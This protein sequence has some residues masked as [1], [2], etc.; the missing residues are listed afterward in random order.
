MNMVVFS[1]MYVLHAHR[2]GDIAYLVVVIAQLMH[3]KTM[4]LVALGKVGER[5]H[6]G[7][8]NER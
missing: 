2:V 6:L 8:R 1:D 3:R 4:Q 7:L 5:I